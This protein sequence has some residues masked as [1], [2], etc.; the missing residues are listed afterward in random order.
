MKGSG[1]GGL[2][3]WSK[4]GKRKVRYET[5]AKA[6]AF[7]DKAHQNGHQRA[8]ACPDCQGWHVGTVHR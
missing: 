4:G 6:Q 3:C 1:L 5:R 2:K 7:L 8:Y